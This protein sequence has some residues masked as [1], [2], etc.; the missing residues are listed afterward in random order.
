MK[1]NITSGPARKPRPEKTSSSDEVQPAQPGP[2]PEAR[3]ESKRKDN[4]TVGLD[5]SDRSCHYV[6]LND[7]GDLVKEGTLPA[8]RSGLN[9]LFGALP[10]SRVALEVGSHSPWMARH[11]AA[12]GHETFVANPRRTR[13]IGSSSNKTDR[14]DAL[15]LARLARLD[16][17][18]LY[19]I[20]H[21]S[22]QAQGHLMI[23]RARAVLV[24]SR[25][26]LINS[27]RGLS[28]SFGE[29][30]KSRDA[31]YVG[32]EMAQDLPPAL[33]TAV[34]PL[35]EEAEALS[36]RIRA[37]DEQLEQ[38]ARDVYPEAVL[39]TQVKG[40]GVLIALTFLLTIEDPARFRRSRDVGAYLGL[41]PKCRQSG[42]ANPQLGISKEGD[43]YLRKLLV[44]SA[45]VIL[46]PK[47]TDS[48]L[49]R[50]GQKLAVQG[51]KSGK[52]KA[53]VAVARKLAILLHHL[54]S[55]GEVYEP[56]YAR[57]QE[58]PATVSQT[59]AA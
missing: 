48:D 34:V 59:A 36:A 8:T 22:E 41:R 7:L 24:E 25:T 35:L 5:L 20:R 45:H 16:P 53:R 52:K 27:A 1:K 28:K 9:R 18:M 33:Q 44:Q 4:L 49:R 47:G 10:R 38:L 37:F 40:V 50:F 3:P 17:N 14:L 39:L 30:L 2:A 13:L 26:R 54:W 51:G 43:V 12:L 46:N 11:I 42:R 32:P 58:Q 55:N 29:R 15:T 56:L 6:I 21:R 23:I 19:P 31:R 57:N